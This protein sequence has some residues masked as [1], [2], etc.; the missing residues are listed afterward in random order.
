MNACA[1]TSMS[2]CARCAV[3]TA[4]SPST[5]GNSSDGE[6]SSSDHP[7]GYDADT[8]KL[9]DWALRVREAE[10]PTLEMTLG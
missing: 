7:T 4:S 1:I 3:I 8:S 2:H 5:S 6:A 10:D 9:V